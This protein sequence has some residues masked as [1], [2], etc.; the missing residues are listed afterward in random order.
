MNLFQGSNGEREQT[1]GHGGR[2]GEEGKS[3]MYI[4]SNMEI[5]NTNGIK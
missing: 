1:Y 4:E 5:Y 2:K 3:K